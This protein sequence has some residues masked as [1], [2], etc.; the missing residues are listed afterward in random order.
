MDKKNITKKIAVIARD[1]QTVAIKTAIGLTLAEDS[2]TVFIVDRQLA[3][4]EET[5]IGIETLKMMNVD[6]IS[7]NPSNKFKQ[8]STEEIANKLTNFDIMIPI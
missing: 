4:T 5:K 1:R 2:V 3:I 7:N 8:M 6:I